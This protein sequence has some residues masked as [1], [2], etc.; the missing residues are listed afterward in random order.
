M[1]VSSISLPPS[2]VLFRAA[3]QSL[4]GRVAR[5][6]LSSD[7]GMRPEIAHNLMAINFEHL[8][9]AKLLWLMAS[10]GQW[11]AAESVG[12][13]QAELAQWV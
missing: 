2:C 10:L 8:F 9:S 5:Y 4:I 6:A 7:F 12:W 3:Y 11:M 13:W 1:Q